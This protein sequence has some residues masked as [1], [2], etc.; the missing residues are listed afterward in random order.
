VPSVLY[1]E[2]LEIPLKLEHDKPEYPWAQAEH[3][4]SL[5]YVLQLRID[6]RHKGP[7]GK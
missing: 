1:D 5:L 3:V 4:P 2:Q 6:G 7:K